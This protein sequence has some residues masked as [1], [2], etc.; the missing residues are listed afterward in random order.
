MLAF[1]E[2]TK[3]LPGRRPAVLGRFRLGRCMVEVSQTADSVGRW[4]EFDRGSMLT[5]ASAE[6][7]KR[8]DR[9]FWR[10]E[11][12]PPVSLYKVGDRYFVE[13]GNRSVS[14]ARPQ[15]VEMIEAKVTQ[16]GARRRFSVGS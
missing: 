5:R 8:M 2:A 9:A 1:E 12:L 3:A 15:G 6:R 13:D 4:R 16:F 10:G 7:W 14:V 11:D